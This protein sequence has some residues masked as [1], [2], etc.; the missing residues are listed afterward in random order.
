MFH[1]RELKT[2]MMVINNIP[3][4]II[5]NCVYGIITG[6]IP[7]VPD[8][9]TETTAITVWTI[10]TIIP[11]FAYSASLSRNFT[12]MIIPPTIPRIIGSANQKADGFCVV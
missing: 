5:I 2:K 11:H 12:Y 1:L 7:V 8:E 9:P 6:A 4:G 10:P 3:R